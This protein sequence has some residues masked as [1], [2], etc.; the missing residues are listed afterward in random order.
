LV[1][2]LVRANG[3]GY[4]EVQ[5]V[6]AVPLQLRKNL[7]DWMGIGIGAIASVQVERFSAASYTIGRRTSFCQL[8]ATGKCIAGDVLRELS[9]SREEKTFDRGNLTRWDFSVFAD[10]QLGLVRKGPAFGIRNVLRLTQEPRYYLTGYLSIK[11]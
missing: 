1:D 5:S 11:I 6:S 3:P 9:F 2:S 10:L 8:D 4:Q 7:N